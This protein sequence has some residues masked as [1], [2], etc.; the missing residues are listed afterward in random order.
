[1]AV[2]FCILILFTCKKWSIFYERREKGCITWEIL[3][4]VFYIGFLE[5]KLKQDF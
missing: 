2:V 1:M 5:G 4:G 3:E